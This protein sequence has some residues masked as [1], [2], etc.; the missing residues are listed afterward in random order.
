MA[1][2]EY[3]PKPKKPAKEYSKPLH[4]ISAG[5][6]V[7]FGIYSLLLI[8][9]LALSFTPEALP[10]QM[11]SPIIMLPVVFLAYLGPL[12]Y[13]IL[14]VPLIITVYLIYA[15]VKAPENTRAFLALPAALLSWVAFIAPLWI[16]AT[17][18]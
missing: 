9:F 13:L 5:L 11:L 10:F 1:T 17:G 3:K 14:L 2:P 12:K 7:I 8:L 15:T 4:T 18:F 16:L 6:T